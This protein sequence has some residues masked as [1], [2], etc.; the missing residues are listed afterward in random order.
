MSFF[1][2]NIYH[3]HNSN[4]E[5]INDKEERSKNSVYTKN[6]VIREISQNHSEHCNTRKNGKLEKKLLVATFYI[7]SPTSLYS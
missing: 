7:A 1:F 2:Q 4:K 3:K 5:H 6:I